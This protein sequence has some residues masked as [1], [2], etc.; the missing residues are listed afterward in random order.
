MLPGTYDESSR[1]KMEYK[2]QREECKWLAEENHEK[3]MDMKQQNLD[4]EHK[5]HKAAMQAQQASQQVNMEMLDFLA[6]PTTKFMGDKEKEK[7]RYLLNTSYIKF[8]T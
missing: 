5:Q 4:M 2:K 6:T 7:I 1:E 3:E 8:H